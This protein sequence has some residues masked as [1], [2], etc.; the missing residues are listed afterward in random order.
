MIRRITLIVTILFSLSMMKANAQDWKALI[1][2]IAKSA[3]GDKATS[4]MTI[5]GSWNYKG[6]ACE[7]ESDNLLAKAG[8]AA[9][10]GKIDTELGKIYSKI[11]FDSARFTFNDDKSYTI[12]IGKITSKGTYTFDPQTKKISM[13]TK[14]GLTVNANVVTLGSNMSLLF[15]ADKLMDALQALTGLASKINTNASTVTALLQ[16]YNGLKV[17]FELTKE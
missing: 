6:A 13:K 16:N 4:E 8:G 14:L 10:T 17:G 1:N 7:F 9:A 3:I 12:A 15:N 11:G 2:D 5:I